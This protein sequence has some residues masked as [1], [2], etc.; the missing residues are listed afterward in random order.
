MKEQVILHVEHI[1]KR[2]ILGQIGGT[3]LRNEL[4]C[5]SARIHRRE[6]P[7]KKIGARNYQKGDVFCALDDIS[8]DVKA[9]ERVGIIGRNGA[10]KSTLLKLI[11]RITAPTSGIIGL[12]GRVASM[13][14]VGTGFHPEL[15]GREN[16]YMNGAILGMSKR[17]ID[18]KIEDIIEFSECRQ[19]IDTPVKRY[20]SGMYVKLAF[21][22]AAHLDS[23]IIIMD[24]VLAVGDMAFQKKCL[25]KMSD[26]SQSQ[27]RTILYVS[28]NMN[29]I[30]QLCSRCI[31]LDHGK[32]I[33]DGEVEEAISRYMDAGGLS[34]EK[35][36][37]LSSAS[38]LGGISRRVLFSSAEINRENNIYTCDE[39]L[40]IS[41]SLESESLQD[42][43]RL[44]MILFYQDGTRIG[45]TES[46]NFSVQPGI[47]EIHVL[48]PNEDLADG[49]Y[50][51]EISILQ[52]NRS[53]AREK[54]DCIPNMIPF[55]IYNTEVFGI[56]GERWQTSY[57]G[58]I[59]MKP[60]QIVLRKK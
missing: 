56:K 6:D 30:R 39:P 16:I 46:E 43:I 34:F 9:G 37:D 12:N 10:G 59:M 5:F 33:F 15:T 51:Y 19:F 2:Y 31:V 29:T 50:Y 4:Q 36:I 8:F 45:K 20:S 18:R 42:D 23:E 54:C 40:D 41:F 26:V 27:G 32:L 22:V 1:S 17:E 47:N 57:Y 48:V 24:E 28:H 58:H 21:S 25:D 14:E 35:K 3:T 49:Q 13:L 55:T 60:I 11:S 52:R 7:T 53:F 38:R 44:M